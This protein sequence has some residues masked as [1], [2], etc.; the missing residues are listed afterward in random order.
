MHRLPQHHF[1][2]L[3][4]QVKV[5]EHCNDWMKS[6]WT[7]LLVSRLEK[8]RHFS[9]L[10]RQ[11]CDKTFKKVLIVRI[12]QLSNLYSKQTGES[13]DLLLLCPPVVSESRKCTIRSCLLAN[14]EEILQVQCQ[15]TS[16]YSL[17]V[18]SSIAKQR[19]CKPLFSFPI[20]AIS[21]LYHC[22][23]WHETTGP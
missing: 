12:V 19:R 5:F 7:C 20:S 14:P 9:F 15:T 3:F 2:I 18:V 4:N 10:K 21:F 13:M 16:F 6:V 1:F 17:K 8:W 11:I 22:G 23:F